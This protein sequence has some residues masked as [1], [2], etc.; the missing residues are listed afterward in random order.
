MAG[1]KNF[2]PENVLF[3]YHT[4]ILEDYPS[5]QL[6]FEKDGHRFEVFREY[7]DCLYSAYGTKWNGN[8]AAYNGSLFIVQDNRIRRLSPLECERLMGFPDNYTDL[9]AAKKTNRYQAIGNSW[10]VPVVRW[11]GERLVEYSGDSIKLDKRR[12][13]LL[14]RTTELP[15]QG[16]FVD[17]GKD[18]AEIG[19]EYA[20]N[21]TATPETCKFKDMSA[22][23]SADAPEDIYISPVGCFGIVRR[24]QERNLKI[25]IR[26]EEVLLSISSQMSAEE[27]E[28]RSRIQKRGRFSAPPGLDMIEKSSNS[29]ELSGSKKTT[30]PVIISNVMSKGKETDDSL[31]VEGEPIQLTLF[32]FLKA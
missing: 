13:F 20:L 5:T 6:T 22:I 18:I 11:I 15:G 3:E 27:I 30:Q 31:S 2:F 24:K 14:A 9:S 12:E 7:T 17:F 10:A 8:A 4:D 23:V 32:D 1:G 19:A 25:N 26:L 28:K 21:C 16:F 29:M